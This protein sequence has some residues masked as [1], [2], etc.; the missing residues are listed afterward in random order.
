MQEDCSNGIRNAL[1][2]MVAEPLLLNLSDS[3]EQLVAP[4][5]QRHVIGISIDIFELYGRGILGVDIIQRSRQLLPASLK[6]VPIRGGAPSLGV[7][8]IGSF[9][10][11]LS[12]HIPCEELE[13]SA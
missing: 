7:W 9:I 3:S 4:P 11:C 13:F 8:S 12:R 6:F 10:D 2:N 5:Q 1:L